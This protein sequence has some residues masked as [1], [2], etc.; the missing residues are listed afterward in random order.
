M[1]TLIIIG[2]IATLLMI[3]LI[4]LLKPKPQKSKKKSGNKKKKLVIKKSPA[5]PKVIERKEKLEKF[6]MMNPN[7]STKLLRNWLNEGGKNILA[8]FLSCSM[9]L[10]IF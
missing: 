6:I 7:Y 2:L 10:S 4:F 5:N 8:L 9:C 3:W 1:I